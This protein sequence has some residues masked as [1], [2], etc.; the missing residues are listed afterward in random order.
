[1]IGKS[2]C[3]TWFY[4]VFILSILFFLAL[5]VIGIDD[6]TLLA[7][8][9]DVI[10]NPKI[11][12]RCD[13]LIKTRDNRIMLKQKAVSLSQRIEKLKQQVP[14]NKKTLVKKLEYISNRVSQQIQLM[15]LQAKNL[16]EDIVRRGCPGISL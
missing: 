2:H 13:E 4:F 15:N 12:S 8:E 5:V 16:E 10:I 1:M 14:I 11:S 6:T 3:F 9:E 7:A